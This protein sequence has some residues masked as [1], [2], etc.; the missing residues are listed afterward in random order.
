MNHRVSLRSYT[1]VLCFCLGLALVACESAA[2][3]QAAQ[4]T[5]VAADV[6]AT[7]TAEAPPTATYTTAPTPTNTAMPTATATHTATPTNTPTHTPTATATSTATPTHTPTSTATPTHTPTPTSEATATPPPPPTA[8]PTNT[9]EPTPT[10]EMIT[11]Y[12]ES[13]PNEHLGTFP[14]Y[15]FDAHAMY[16][17]MTH[18]KEQ[19]EV[20]NANLG[21]A[22]QGDAAACQAYVNA[23]ESIIDSG[24]FYKD[25]PGHWERIHFY[26]VISFIYSLDRT[27]PAYLSCKETGKVNQFDF[28]LAWQALDLTFKV[29]NPAIDEAKATLPK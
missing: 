5:Q 13:N 9:P 23:Y 3:R 12:Y 1:V 22:G 24:A 19:L 28:G 27:R 4:A 2:S 21:G 7:Q 6:F 16:D 20:M 18:L 25:P 26:Y 17:K 15:P 29:L 8:T 11:L 14:E 10:P